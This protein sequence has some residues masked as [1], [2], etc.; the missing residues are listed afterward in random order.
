MFLPRGRGCL[1]RM[2]SAEEVMKWS[3]D[4]AMV[5]E[6]TRVG[7]IGFRFGAWG[8]G[9]GGVQEGGAGGGWGGRFKGGERTGQKVGD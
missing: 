8:L 9:E 4:G 7:L 5:M 2:A 3:L 1:A 6:R